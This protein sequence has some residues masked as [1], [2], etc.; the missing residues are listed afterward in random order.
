MNL[1][2][3]SGQDYSKELENLL[4]KCLNFGLVVF[5]KTAVKI[6]V[7]Y[8]VPLLSLTFEIFLSTLKKVLIVV[9]FL[10]NYKVPNSHRP[11]LVL[12]W[13]LQGP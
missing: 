10:K 13:T 4:M 1:I 3:K 7:K 11:A 12:P 9:D 5:K 2:S 8:L 6:F